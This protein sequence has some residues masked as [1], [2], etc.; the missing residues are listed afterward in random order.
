[1]PEQR[2]NPLSL[3]DSVY[4]NSAYE[5]HQS[6]GAL[7]VQSWD[8]NR[9][10]GQIQGWIRACGGG[11]RQWYQDGGISFFSCPNPYVGGST[12]LELINQVQCSNQNAEI[13]TFSE[14]QVI[15]HRRPIS[16]HEG[17]RLEY[18]LNPYIVLRQA[19]ATYQYMLLDSSGCLHPD[20]VPPEQLEL[21]RTT[22]TTARVPNA[23]Y[24]S[25]NVHKVLN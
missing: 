20:S 10:A 19:R 18:D 5:I 23:W 14:G 17:Y 12:N 7:F 1:M 21:V 4:T 3:T 8:T 11:E 15:W 22:W 25:D 16:V 24:C 9:S 6:I 2:Q 13:R